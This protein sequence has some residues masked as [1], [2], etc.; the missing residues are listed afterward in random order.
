MT[1]S[2]LVQLSRGTLHVTV[3]QA[4]IAP[5]QLFDFAERRNPKRAFLFVSKVLGRHIPVKPSVMAHAFTQLAKQIPDH[6]P[7]PVLVIGMAETAVGLGAGVHRALQQRYPQAMY[8]M[9]TRHSLGTP[10]FARFEEEHSHASSHLL[11]WPVDEALKQQLLASKT[12]IIVDDEASTGKTFINLAQALQDA[13]LQQIERIIAATLTD[14]SGDAV[15]AKLGKKAQTVSLL[16][17]SYQW[18]ADLNA[19]LPEMP[20]V[21]SV[22]QGAWQPNLALDWGRLGVIHHQPTLNNK[23]SVNKGEKILVLGTSEYV[24]RSFLLAEHLEQQGAAVYFASTT[25]SPI[26][27]GHAIKIARAFSDNYGLGIANFSYNVD[28]NQYDKIIICTE[29]PATMLDQALLAELNA[30]VIVDD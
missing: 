26:A 21:D 4:S 24:W 25:R 27:V 19:A 3:E 14:W 11:H 12:L 29:T 10:L 17:G 7:E 13:G 6:L 1:S 15:Q 2:F 28:V 16:S 18:Q 5:E 22:A 23:I 20:K 30:Q 9:S 8:W